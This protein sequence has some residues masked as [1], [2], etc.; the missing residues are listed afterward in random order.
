MMIGALSPVHVC[1][2]AKRSHYELLL[3]RKRDAEWKIVKKRGFQ[4]DQDELELLHPTEQQLKRN[5]EATDF[6]WAAQFNALEDQVGVHHHWPVEMIELSLSNH[7]KR[8]D[9]FKACCF[10]LGNGCAPDVFVSYVLH[11]RALHD[12]PARRDVS[13]IIKDLLFLHKMGTG[14]RYH[15]YSLLWQKYM[16]IKA[17]SVMHDMHG[18]N[19]VDAIKML[20]MTLP[21]MT[22]S[23]RV[24]PRAPVVKIVP[25]VEDPDAL[26]TF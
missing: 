7:W 14:L 3:Q 5:A 1:A 25:G 21:C 15:Y 11:M 10:F 13:N 2:G 17:Q 9:R 19:F 8:P 20:G 4:K 12:E 16:R 26:D 23:T 22:Q 18:K 6:A 24:V